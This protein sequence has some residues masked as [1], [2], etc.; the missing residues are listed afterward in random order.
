[1]ITSSSKKEE[2]IFDKE[3]VVKRLLNMGKSSTV[4]LIP[5][6]WLR[7]M[8]LVADGYVRLSFDGKKIEI[9][10]VHT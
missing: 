6:V 5:Q 10:N 3:Q 9:E 4:V 7:E 8:G 1:M 2:K